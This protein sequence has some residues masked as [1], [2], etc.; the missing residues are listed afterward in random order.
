[1][2]AVADWVLTVLHVAVVA[3]F[4]VLWIPR[5]TAHLYPWLV[6]AVASS[7]LILGAWRGLGYCVLT[8]WH[9]QVKRARG[10]GRLP[11]S[12]LKYAADFVAGRDVPP[13][14]VDA[15]AGAVFVTGCI[16][17]LW[18]VVR[19]RPRPPC[20]EGLPGSFP[21]CRWRVIVSE[22]K[23]PRGARSE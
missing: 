7:W 8:D 12:F 14:W 2:L 20:R 13:R 11:G 1:M 22:R 10:E 21:G 6:G 23:R 18:I 4:L 5:R 19:R 15:V 16:L 3:S 9:W 17:A